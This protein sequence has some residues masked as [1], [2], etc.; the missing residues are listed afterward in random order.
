MSQRLE[1]VQLET[2]ASS[3]IGHYDRYAERFWE[4]TKDHDVSQNRDALIRHLQGTPPQTILD[5]GCGPGRDLMIFKEAGFEVVGLDGSQK[6][7]EAA[8][9]YSGCEVWQQNFLELDL[10]ELYFDGIFANA[11]LFHVPTQELGRVLGQLH[12]SLKPGGTFFASNPRGE[13]SEGFSQHDSRYGAYWDVPTWRAMCESAGF[14]ELEHY[15]R[16]PG[17]PRN[18]QPW[19]A[20]VWRKV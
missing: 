17:R 12:A 2:I 19:L 9:K 3:T 7:C 10:P 13:N 11:S 15:Y 1:Q 18:Q 4:G 8:R 14:V 5:L 20:T 6:F 16:P